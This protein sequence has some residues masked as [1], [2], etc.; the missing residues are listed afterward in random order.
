MERAGRLIGKLKLDVDD[1]ELRARA[2]WKVAAGKK[3]A[4]HTRAV[5]L[6]RGSLVVEVED[7][8]WQRQL[9]TLSGFLLRNLEKALG[10]ALVTDVD[11]R[12]MPRRREPQRAERARGTEDVQD[13][14]LDLLY[15]QSRKKG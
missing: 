5:A 9:K 8:I 4:E 12:P 15:R 14:V 2:A 1:P 6:V 3:I 11:F 7:Q 10:E 13:P